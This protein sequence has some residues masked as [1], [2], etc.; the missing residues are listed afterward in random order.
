LPADRGDKNINGTKLILGRFGLP[1]LPAGKGLQ[2]S[3]LINKENKAI[4]I[5]ADI[6]I[7]KLVSA[8]INLSIPIS[9]LCIFFNLNTCQLK[10]IE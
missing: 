4:G 1:C 9:L 10:K 6:H 7:K 3:V 5:V 8:P 2:S